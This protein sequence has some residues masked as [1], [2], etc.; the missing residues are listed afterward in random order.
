MFLGQ[1]TNY[2]DCDEKPVRYQLM[3]Y[4][5]RDHYTIPCLI[6]PGKLRD[7]YTITWTKVLRDNDAG[8]F[9]L[10]SVNKTTFDLY[11]GANNLPPRRKSVTCKV[12]IE[13]DSSNDEEYCGPKLSLAGM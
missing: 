11:L 4:S 5:E 12:D 3:D 7:K 10:S 13:H 9:I 6:K 8:F 1:P 2:F